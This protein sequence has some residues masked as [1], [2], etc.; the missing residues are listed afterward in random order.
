MKENSAMKVDP[1][2]NLEEH[3]LSILDEDKMS[4]SIALNLLMLFAYYCFYGLF[5]YFLISDWKS[6]V[7]TSDF[8]ANYVLYMAVVLSIIS[9]LI[10]F[11]VVFVTMSRFKFVTQSFKQS[12]ADKRISYEVYFTQ[13]WDNVL[14]VLCSIF[15]GLFLIYS[16]IT[17]NQCDV[18]SQALS[19]IWMCD[20]GNS[21]KVLRQE[22]LMM[23]C[24]TPIL[25]AVAYRV[26]AEVQ[27]LNWILCM[28]AVSYSMV[29]RKM[30]FSF[31][32][33]GLIALFGIGILHANHVQSTHLAQLAIKHKGL[34]ATEFQR[35][36]VVTQ[37]FEIRLM[38]NTL[39]LEMKSV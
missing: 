12:A 4:P 34:L 17:K 10:Y 27:I 18:S 1:I 36:V 8:L 11:W 21:T 35:T 20:N 29:A 16:A 7:F 2:K 38:I 28:A 3:T 30:Y 26:S 33:L 39:V 37:A 25:F 14:S 5:G 31:I 32:Y 19:D 15:S 13:K 23:T 24:I 9:V 22:L 6:L